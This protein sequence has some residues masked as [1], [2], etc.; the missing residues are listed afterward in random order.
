MFQ[1]LGIRHQVRIAN[2]QFRRLPIEMPFL[3]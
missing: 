3:D 1:W 2:F